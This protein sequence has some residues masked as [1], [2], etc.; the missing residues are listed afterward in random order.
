MEQNLPLHDDATFEKDKQKERHLLNQL[1]LTETFCNVAK[2]FC[3]ICIPTKNQRNKIT[4]KQN[5]QETYM[6]TIQVNLLMQLLM[7]SFNNP[8][9]KVFIF[10][11]PKKFSLCLSSSQQIS[12]RH[13]TINY[14]VRRPSTFTLCNLK[15]ILFVKNRVV[16][17]VRT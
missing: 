5:H 11:Q 4:E 1:F 8:R 16:F 9:K 13:Q 17:V 15:C 2:Q 3:D 7:F 10:V 6:L 12:S 14:L